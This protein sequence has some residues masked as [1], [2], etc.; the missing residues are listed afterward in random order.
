MAAAITLKTNVEL[1]VVPTHAKF[2]GGLVPDDGGKLPRDADGKL[3]V[4]A[5][6]ERLVAMSPVKI[7]SAQISAFPGVDPGDNDELITG[8]RA[9]GVIVHLVMMVGG[10]DPM[11]P[12]DEDKVVEMLVAGLELAKKYGVEHVGS[13]S[14]EEW[15]QPGAQ[16][17]VGADFEAAVAQNVKVHL[18]AYEEAGV[19]NSGIKAW[20]V[21]FL[22]KGEFQTFTDVSKLWA[23]IKKVNISLGSPF[24]K[25]LV[26]AAHCGDSD[27]SIPENIAVVREIAEAGELGIFHASA[28][29]TRGCLSTDDGWVGALLTAC[30]ETGKLEFAFVELFLP[31]RGC[32]PGR[33]AE[34]RSR[35]RDRHHRRAYV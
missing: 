30:A 15:M 7:A 28:R 2:V 26:D 24:F 21:E 35:T 13:T 25:V 4:L 11:N 31:P 1:G 32:R 3:V 18:R 19:A 8:L 9:A 34:A 5:E 17:K 33:A 12:A 10:A 22:R 23:F 6:V 20:H 16:P 29:T 27:L 14:V